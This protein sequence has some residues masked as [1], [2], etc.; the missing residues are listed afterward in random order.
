MG[1]LL[2]DIDRWRVHEHDRALAF[3]WVDVVFVALG[4][5]SNFEMVERRYGIIGHVEIE[6]ITV[7]IRRFH[8]VPETCVVPNA[9]V[10]GESAAAPDRDPVMRR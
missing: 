5:N 7:G 1:R 9:W 8:Q 2:L 10:D 3:D 6:E 4:Q